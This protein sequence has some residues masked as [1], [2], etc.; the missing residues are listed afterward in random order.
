MSGEGT[1]LDRFLGGRVT[2]V[3][4]AGGFRAGHDTVLLASAVPA[5][6]GSTA[7]ELGA[8]AGIASLCLAA[9]VPDVRIMGI[10]IDPDLVRLANENAARNDMADRMSFT[11]SDARGFTADA[12]AFDHVFFNPPFHPDTGQKSPV[13]ARDRATR[14][15]SDAVRAWTKT[16]LSLTRPDGTVTAI[17]R[18]DRVEDILDEARGFGGVVFPLL[19]RAG[20]APKRA[21]VRI[22]KTGGGAF[23]RALG[24]ILHEADGRNSEAAEAVLRHARPLW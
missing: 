6:P 18:A 14:D 19:P 2:A 1:T 23:S 8:G 9:R 15:T 12:I 20:V 3:Q 21:I 5:V 4:P 7:L 13:P 22:V 16:A 24:L 17:I 11:L 10:D